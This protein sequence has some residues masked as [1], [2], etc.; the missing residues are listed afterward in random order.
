M[1]N[2]ILLATLWSLLFVPSLFAQEFEYQ[3]K[4]R[5]GIE[6]GQAFGFQSI[7]MVEYENGSTSDM[8]FGD[9]T[10]VGVNYG[11]QFAKHFDLSSSF[12]YYWS[13][14]TPKSKYGSVVFKSFRISLT[15]AFVIPLGANGLRRFRVGAGLDFCFSNQLKL[16]LSKMINGV[17]DNWT[18]DRALG[19]HFNALYESYFINENWSSYL[20]VQYYGVGYSFVSGSVAHPT[21]SNLKS[22]N[23]NGVGLIF[24][25]NYR[26]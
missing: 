11:Y 17:N 1:R 18:Y 6:F 19:Y 15:P 13:G 22:P 9:C 21:D 14:L 24:G 25:V 12:G 10:G 20:G 16:N 3:P 4:N 7:P 8:K 5:I 23:G 2:Y 26:F